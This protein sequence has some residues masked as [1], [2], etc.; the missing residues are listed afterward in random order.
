MPAVT[1]WKAV[2]E[3]LTKGISNLATSACWAALVGG[4]L[5][6]VME[7]I[8]L[9]TKGG[10]WISCVGIGLAAVIPFNT[11]FAMF[12]GSF[13]FWLAERVFR[14]PEAVANRVIVQN[15][16]PICAGVIAGGAIMGIAVIILENFVLV[17]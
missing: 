4:L 16:E 17:G 10:F 9:A 13:L 5:G 1:I 6:L 3:V 11:C 12:L 7:G 2:A 15:Q 8:R 14:K